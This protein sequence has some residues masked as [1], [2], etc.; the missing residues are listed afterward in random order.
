MAQHIAVEPAGELYRR[1][2][3]K[4]DYKS[5]ATPGPGRPGHGAIGDVNE[6]GK[7]APTAK[8]LEFG[9]RQ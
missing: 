1:R 4:P 3:Y 8:R 2:Y 7:L 6:K 5:G 9:G